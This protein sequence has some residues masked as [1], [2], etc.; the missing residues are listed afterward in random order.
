[1]DIVAVQKAIERIEG[2]LTETQAKMRNYL[3]ELGFDK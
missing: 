3:K 2:E 1:V